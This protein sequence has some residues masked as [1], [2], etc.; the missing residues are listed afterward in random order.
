MGTKRRYSDIMHKKFRFL[1]DEQLNDYSLWQ[2]LT[3]QFRKHSDDC[4][5]G[6]RGEF[7]GKLMRGACLIYQY[8]QD[9]A[10]YKTLY[11]AVEDLLSTQ[12][13]FGRISSYSQSREFGDWDI[14]GR[15][16]VLL[17]LEHFH[18]ICKS[19]PLR[20]RIIEALKLQADYLI[21]HIGRGKIPI[22]QTSRFYSALNSTSVLQPIVRLYALTGDTRYYDYAIEL[23]EM[24]DAEGENI[25]ALAFKNEKSPFEYPVVKAYEMISCFEGLLDFYRVSKEEKC[26]QACVRFADKV[27]STDF[28]VIGGSGCKEELFDNSTKT[29]VVQS[30]YIKQETCV[31]VTLMKFLTELYS[32]V[33][34]VKYLNAVE[35]ILYNIYFG[36]MNDIPN[37]AYAARPVFNSYS[38]IYENPRWT[39]MGGMKNISPYAMFG[40]C[41]AI[42]AAGLGQIPRLDCAY[43]C[44]E[45]RLS[46][47]IDGEYIVQTPNGKIKLSVKT[48]Y[49]REGLVEIFVTDDD[50]KGAP[51]LLR[52]PDWCSK[53]T[54]QVNGTTVE[55]CEKEGFVQPCILLK[56]GMSVVYNMEMPLQVIRSETFNAEESGLFALQRGPIMLCADSIKNDLTTK[57]DCGEQTNLQFKT[58]GFGNYHVIFADGVQAEFSEY[59]LCG[60][61][62]YEPRKIS[63]WLKKK[64]N[65]ENEKTN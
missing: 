15:K 23:I 14:W 24:Q 32:D 4:D 54:L 6:W 46:Y 64:T 5:N 56:R 21:Q 59:R 36:A 25:F 31:S 27:L 51:L 3:N 50:G 9:E 65:N 38:P 10:L 18:E 48:N 26:L 40:C 49:P 28:T 37:N 2:L 34:D 22:N 8:D 45:I 12:D 47:F 60:R 44:G 41:V 55:C 30:D 16:Y 13:T 43:V 42:G 53:Y 58:D 33:K 29:Q 7:W 61:D 17:G 11:T 19:K 1:I 39:L 63:V 62:Y 20:K 35:K 52:I 57:Y